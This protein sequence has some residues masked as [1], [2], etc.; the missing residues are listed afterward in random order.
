MLTRLKHN[1][2]FGASTSAYTV[3]VVRAH[4]PLSQEQQNQEQE[5]QK[6]AKASTKGSAKGSKSSRA[7]TKAISSVD[8]MSTKSELKMIGMWI[9][10]KCVKE[11]RKSF[12]L[13]I[14]I[15]TLY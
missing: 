12:Y 1:H 14:S 5:K 3:R 2:G 15:L 6:S 7:A 11:V 4:I 8:T 10:D 13:S 9:P